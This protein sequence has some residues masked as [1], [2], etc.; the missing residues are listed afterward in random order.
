LDSESFGICLVFSAADKEGKAVIELILNRFSVLKVFF[1]IFRPLQLLLFA[2]SHLF[3]V[4]DEF[5]TQ[6][7][8]YPSR[9]SHVNGHL[10]RDLLNS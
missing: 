4:G 6:A 7:R 9:V 3:S 5:G 10:R 2:K 8:C 1:R